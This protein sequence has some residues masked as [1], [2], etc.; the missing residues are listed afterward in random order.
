MTDAVVLRFLIGPISLF[1]R[2]EM[3][4]RAPSLVASI[5]ELANLSSRFKECNHDNET[6]T[7]PLLQLNGKG[8]EK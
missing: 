4:S 5:A 8:L 6:R 7:G 2:K 3:A 1:V